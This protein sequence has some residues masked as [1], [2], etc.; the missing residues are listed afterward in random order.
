MFEIIKI[1]FNV[2]Y[3]Y[4]FILQLLAVSF[5]VVWVFYPLQNNVK[6]VFIAIGHM[7]V[8]FVAGI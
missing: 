7:V 6:S 1:F 2:V 5:S 4:V 3:D 8:V